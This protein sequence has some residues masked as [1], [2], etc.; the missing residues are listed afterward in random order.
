M[1]LH[2]VIYHACLFVCNHSFLQSSGAEDISLT[3]K[4]MLMQFNHVS[5]QM[6]DAIVSEYPSP[7]SLF[8]VIL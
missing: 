2:V 6:S 1:C 7:S 4:H 8:K 5:M 3:W